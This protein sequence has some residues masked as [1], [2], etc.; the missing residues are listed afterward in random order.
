M[1][2]KRSVCCS[3]ICIEANC[4]E[5]DVLLPSSYHLKDWLLLVKPP[6][7]FHVSK[8]VITIYLHD[9]MSEGVGLSVCLFVYLETGSHFVAQAGLK[10]AMEIRMTWNSQRFTCLCFHSAGLKK[11]HCPT[12]NS[13]KKKILTVK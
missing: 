11:A 5:K 4:L 1:H 12:M 2:F 10:V 9:H 3:E 7:T 6:D 8:Y 13:F